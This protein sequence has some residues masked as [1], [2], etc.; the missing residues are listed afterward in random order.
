[1]NK[2]Q[3]NDIVTL[4]APSRLY[5]V[6]EIFDYGSKTLFHCWEIGSDGDRVVCPDNRCDGTHV[7]PIH[8]V[9]AFTGEIK[10]LSGHEVSYYEA[11]GLISWKLS[12]AARGVEA[13]NPPGYRTQS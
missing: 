9:N 10:T 5:A 3:L 1:M 4:G 8:G 2:P 12:C 6:T 11:H 7:C 13:V